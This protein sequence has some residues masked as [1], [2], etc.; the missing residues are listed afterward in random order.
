MTVPT[1]RPLTDIIFSIDTISRTGPLKSCA[2]VYKQG[3]ETIRLEQIERF[4]VREPPKSF[5]CF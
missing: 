1:I 4:N 2:D 3:K 5:C